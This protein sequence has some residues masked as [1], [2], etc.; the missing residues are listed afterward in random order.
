MRMPLMVAALA[1]LAAAPA[2]AQSATWTVGV[3]G[4]ATLPIGDAADAYDTGLNLAITLGAR[5]AGGGIGYGVE[6]QVHR[7]GTSVVDGNLTGFAGFGRLEFPVGSQL[8][9]I[10]GAGVFRAETTLDAVDLTTT[11]TDFA[12]QAGAGLNIGRALF[13][14]AKLIN[15]F[16]DDNARFL[17]ITVGFRF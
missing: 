5:P 8:Y 9:L 17:P 13:A 15:V 12:I 4:G 3:G 2:A 7:L 10:G 11:T 16:A 6:A 1:A 14:E